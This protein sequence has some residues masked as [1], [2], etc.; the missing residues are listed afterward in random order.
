MFEGTQVV[1]VIPCYRVGEHI[2]QVIE[3]LPHWV[4]NIV[5]VNDCCPEGTGE[6]LARIQDPRLKIITL[7]ENKGVGGAMLAGYAEALDLGGNIIIKMDGDG[8]MDPAYLEDLIAPVAFLGY[9]YAKGNRF[10]HDKQLQ[11]MPSVRL[12]GNIVLTFLTKIASGYWNVFDPQNGYTVISRW[13]LESINL[14]ELDRRYFFENQMLVLLNTRMVPVADVPIPAR[15]GN[16]TSSLRIG[17]VLKSFPGLLVKGF[18]TRLWRR[19]VILDF[20]PLIPLL[21]AGIVFIAFGAVFGGYH[22][23]KSIVTNVP[24]TSGT[25]MLAVLP[26]IIGAQVIL[27][28]ILIDIAS[29]PK[30]DVSS[31]TIRIHP[32]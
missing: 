14:E 18:L 31:Q 32:N 11:R 25:V 6:A 26:L 22:W 12:W 30:A 16:E 1:I 29:V 23:I 13:A 20:S 7:K 24:A 2:E 28:A 5:A 17:I 15:Y 21:V 19:H 3:F 10:L 8:Q 27:Q 9:G 4:D